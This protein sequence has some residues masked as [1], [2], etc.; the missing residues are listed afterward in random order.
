MPLLPTDEEAALRSAVRAIA[1]SFG[2]EYYTKMAR[3]YQQPVDL[4]AQ[5]G[6]NGFLGVHLPSEFDGGGEGL[7]E[8]AIVVEEAAAAGCPVQQMIVHAI[9]GCI[10]SRW[11][12]DEQKLRWLP[13]LA[14]GEVTF[15]FSIT[16]PDAGSNAHNITTTARRDGDRYLINGQKTF[17]SGAD[18]ADAILVVARTGTHERSGHGLLSL[19]I[20]DPNAPGL[21]RQHIPT[22][23]M[24]GGKSFQLFF[25]DVEVSADQ[26][27]GVE[28]E[29]WRPLFDGLNPERILAAATC[30]GLARFALDKA[31]RYA[32]DRHVWGVAIGE[33]QGVA[34][35]L[36]EAKI[37]LELARLMTAKATALYDAGVDA[38][39]S[40]NIAKMASADAAV[41]AIDQAIQVH[42]GN[43]MALETGLT[44]AYWIARLYRIAPVSREMVLNYVAQHSLGLPRSY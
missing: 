16:E 35:P 24:V 3:Q 14:A 10:L 29:G 27:V 33:H 17:C 38:G 4:M 25:D 43:G 37:E 30:N 26:L 40:T 36:A 6:A 11:G 15:A 21:V 32:N 12:S 1:G 31:A 5:L 20:V 8:L 34:H 44:D 9:V 28:N 2:W 7:T 18:R 42:G 23:P 19:F 41:H 22:A 13:G 39:E